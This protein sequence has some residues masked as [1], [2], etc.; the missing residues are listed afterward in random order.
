MSSASQPL[1]TGPP[2][3]QHQNQRAPG[4]FSPMSQPL[5]SRPALRRVES[6]DGED[7]DDNDEKLVPVVKSRNG[8][9]TQQH[10]S[11]AG[12]SQRPFYSSSP[13]TS[14]T[15]SLQNFSRPTINTA[16]GLQSSRNA[17]PLSAVSKSATSDF[18]RGHS[19]K[20]SQ[21]QGSF[22]PYL[23]TAAHSNIGNMAN[24]NNV[25]SAS[26][27]AAQAAMQQQAHNRQRSQ[28][29]PTPMQEGLNV[30]QTRRPSRAGP[31]SPPTLS[32][33]E[34]SGPREQSFGGQIYQNG[35]L[36]GSHGNAAQTAANLVFP[37]SPGAPPSLPATTDHDPYAVHRAQQEKPLKTEKSK[38]KLFSR[39]AKIGISKDKE[40]KAGALPSPNP[41]SSAASIYSMANSS[42]ATIRA[43]E[44]QAPEK[45]KDKEKHK[46]H[47]LSRQKHKLSSKDDH[48]LNLS[49]SAS[50]SRPVD[51]SAP[52]SIYNFNIPPSPGPTTTSFAKSMSGL[53]LWHG[54]RALR[55]KKKEEKS[56]ALREGELSYQISNE[57]PG[58]SSLGS[59]G[60]ASL[61]GSMAGSHA[62]PSSVYGLDPDL[63]SKSGLLNL[64]PD[65]AWPYLK[66]KLLIIFEG[67]DLRL[68]VED[69]NRLVTINL[70][71]CIQ[72]RAPNMIVED[73][74]DLLA[75]GFGSLDFTL[76][77]TPDDRL[78]SH[79]VEMWMFTFTSVLPYMQAVFLPLDLEFSGQ[80]PL[81]NPE[82]ARDFW[83]ALSSPNIPA[84]QGLEV[85]RI[86]LAA[87]RDTVI[88]PRFDTLKTIFSRLSLES[89]SFSIP[90]TDNLSTS[91][92]SSG[93]RPSTAISLD[94]AHASYGS[95]TTTLL[96]GGSSGDGS[97]SR[98]RAISNV[99]YGSE[100]S[101][102]GLTNLPPPPAR[103]FTPS[104]T[105]PSHPLNRG[106]RDKTVEDSSK[107]LTE[108][109]GRML[110]CMSVLM[111]VGVGGGGD[112]DSQRKMEE[113]TRGLKLNW[114][115]RGRMGRNRRGLVGAKVPGMVGKD[116]SVI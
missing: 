29:V 68:P 52:S 16:L 46:H 92:D 90:T 100:T 47:F 95:Q 17:S 42:T 81:M 23:P 79:L 69:F 60:A 48:S 26:Q 111:S 45:E 93:R 83:G 37:K 66:A 109:V 21:T 115:G 25:L 74:R 8:S 89:I 77:R 1:R 18:Y 39:P 70:Q 82:Q 40:A 76:R 104:S 33:T 103:P 102:L 87:Y 86:V 107:Q 72:K 113:L 9:V 63:G 5:I 27:I 12:L 62:Y 84:S 112:E 36:G 50:N 3:H 38:V 31:T 54:G 101:G 51:P 108:T 98:S 32:L 114:L 20:H 73:L 15:T 91:P 11:T 4:S 35:L 34:A 30:P 28:T 57:W 71:R 14:S 10:A 61:V 94:P 53:D 6:S 67:E 80:G 19:R 24:H 55:E 59:V 65:D 2:Q 96:G 13:A 78:I 44:S 75:T 97:G 7:D 88:L 116:I 64:G 110:Q 106:Q 58:P 105:H 41:S 43:V 85:R 22:E 49:S 99:S 56:D